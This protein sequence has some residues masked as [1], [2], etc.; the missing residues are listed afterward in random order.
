VTF[1]FMQL[2][3]VHVIITDPGISAAAAQAIRDKGIEVIL[4]APEQA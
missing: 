3:E 1:L 4:A 2:T